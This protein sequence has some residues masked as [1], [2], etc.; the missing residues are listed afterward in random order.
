MPPKPDDFHVTGDVR[1]PNPGYEAILCVK[2]P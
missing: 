2:Q 1:V